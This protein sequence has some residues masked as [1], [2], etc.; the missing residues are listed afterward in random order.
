MNGSSSVAQMRIVSR[1]LYM[2]V[3][4]RAL[5]ASSFASA[6][7]IVS[8]IYLLARWM[9][10]KISSSAFWNWNFSICASTRSR[11]PETREIR[12]SSNSPAARSAGRV[13]PKYFSTIAV[14]RE[15]R[16]PRSFARSML[17]VLI[18]SSLEKL[19]SE[20]NGNVRSRKKRSASTPNISASTYG[21]TTLPLDFDILPPS[22][23]SQPWP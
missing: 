1:R 18:R 5:L 3:A 2:T 13:P 12:L 14:V 23:T 8:S 16:F 20:P 10:L 22:M 11:R 21:S 6:H 17:M 9:H 4:R 19:P 7:G 15:T